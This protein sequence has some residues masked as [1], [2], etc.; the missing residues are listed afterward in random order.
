MGANSLNPKLPPWKINWHHR[1][2][3][4][5]SILI[6][7]SIINK[8]K[9]LKEIITFTAKN[10]ATD[11]RPVREKEVRDPQILVGFAFGWGLC[12]VIVGVSENW[13]KRVNGAATDDSSAAICDCSVTPKR[14][15]CLPPR[16]VRYTLSIRPGRMCRIWGRTP[17]FM[18]VWP[19]IYMLSEDKEREFWHS[20]WGVWMEFDLAVYLSTRKM[21]LRVLLY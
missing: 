3:Q 1:K 17:S 19:T 9:K 13:E 4:D 5:I 16:P 20:S 8:Y 6:D 15:D 12:I 7:T 21:L 11:A 18:I 14:E 2:P 10:F